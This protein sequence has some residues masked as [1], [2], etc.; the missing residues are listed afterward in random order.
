MKKYKL[1]KVY[2]GI[3]SRME[4]GSV[5]AL[6]RYMQFYRYDDVAFK[7][8]F[9]TIEE[10]ENNPEYWQEVLTPK[11]EILEARFGV[12]NKIWKR[13]SQLKDVF[14]S[15]RPDGELWLMSLEEF[16]KMREVYEGAHIIH[17]VIRLPDGQIFTVGDEIITTANRYN[18]PS[19]IVKISKDAVFT[20]ESGWIT[21]LDNAELPLTPKKVL[22]KSE[23]GVEILENDDYYVVATGEYTG[24]APKVKAFPLWH[25]FFIKGNAEVTRDFDNQN[26][27][28]FISKTKAKMFIIMNA[29]HVTVKEVL[30]SVKGLPNEVELDGDALFKIIQDKF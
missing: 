10:I 1:I 12:S 3:P 29:P 8:R 25:L 13:D 2:P 22:G 16:L 9:F 15:R 28:R 11:F 30:E 23:E 27:K 18:S 17:S 4:V 7:V 24:T 26:I 14:Y 20:L 5:V 21:L 19:R 6:K